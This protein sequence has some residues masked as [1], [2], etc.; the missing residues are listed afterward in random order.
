MMIFALPS[1]TSADKAGNARFNWVEPY[2]CV[3]FSRDRGTGN[4]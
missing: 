1:V 2:G 3:V 4:L